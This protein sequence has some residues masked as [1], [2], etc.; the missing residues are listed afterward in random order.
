[1]CPQISCLLEY[2]LS[3]EIPWD[4][5][6]PSQ[7]LMIM[8]CL[9]TREIESWVA[10]DA[11]KGFIIKNPKHFPTFELAKTTKGLTTYKHF[12]RFLIFVEYKD[13][14]TYNLFAKRL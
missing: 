10:R 11:F 14:L 6:D 9:E 13:P 7:A 1:M 5:D 2:I 8:I 3:E 4:F 12:K